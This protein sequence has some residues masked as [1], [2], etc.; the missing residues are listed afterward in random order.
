MRVV[1]N[2]KCRENK[3]E[4]AQSATLCAHFL[5]CLDRIVVAIRFKRTELLK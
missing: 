5:T 4:R 1:M 2:L 3:N